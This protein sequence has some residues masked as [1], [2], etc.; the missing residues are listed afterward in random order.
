MLDRERRRREILGGVRLRPALKNV[1]VNVV[2]LEL[3]FELEGALEAVK[4]RDFRFL[5]M[6]LLLLPEMLET[7]TVSAVR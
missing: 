1:G 4:E 6:L 7:W 2:E 3:E 5:L